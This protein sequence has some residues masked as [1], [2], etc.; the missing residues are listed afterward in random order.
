MF[1]IRNFAKTLDTVSIY[2]LQRTD[3]NEYYYNGIKHYIDDNMN[4]T[5][6][7]KRA[8]YISSIEQVMCTLELLQEHY[9]ISFRILKLC[10][11]ININNFKRT[12]MCFLPNKIKE[13]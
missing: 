13:N 1:R 2:V 5:T 11:D 9:K 12:E 10:H 8:A 6:D 7:I 3:T 4:Y